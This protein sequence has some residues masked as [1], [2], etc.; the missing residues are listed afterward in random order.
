MLW[1]LIHSSSQSRAIKSSDNKV[2]VFNWIVS[3]WGLW[4]QRWYYIL[5]LTTA[6][7]K[8]EDA[9]TRS[10]NFPV[11]LYTLFT[12]AEHQHAEGST[13]V[14]PANELP[15]NEFWQLSCQQRCFMHSARRILSDLPP[16]STSPSSSVS[17]IGGGECQRYRMC[18]G[19]WG[20]GN[21]NSDPVSSHVGIRH[22]ADDKRMSG[23]KSDTGGKCQFG[24]V[25][26]W[27]HVLSYDMCQTTPQQ[28]LTGCWLTNWSPPWTSLKLAYSGILIPHA[29]CCS[30][31]NAMKQ[32]LMLLVLFSGWAH[33]YNRRLV[34]SPFPP[35]VLHSLLQEWNQCFLSFWQII[36]PSNNPLT[37]RTDVLLFLHTPH[38]P[39]W[40]ASGHLV[41][42]PL[43]D[44]AVPK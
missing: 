27:V 10:W 33:S 30:A 15:D 35:V 11:S 14:K 32:H 2:L 41:N 38:T 5:S 34:L 9:N 25:N 20:G 18:V 22:M 43:E 23:Q 42:P 3:N 29:N 13:A 8:P 24:F 39:T 28:R 37:L 26:I 31:Q 17:P 6:A 19:Y 12:T 21:C 36:E 16:T 40:T 4:F 44:E 7:Q 1:I